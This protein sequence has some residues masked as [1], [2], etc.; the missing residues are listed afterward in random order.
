M[1]FLGSKYAKIADGALPWT[2]L[3]EL[4]HS[5]DLLAAIYRPTCKG[6][7]RGGDRPTSRNIGEEEGRGG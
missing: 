4:K 3:W 1:L 2:P 5:P 7:R 6:K